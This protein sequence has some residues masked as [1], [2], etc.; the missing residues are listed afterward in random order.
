[1]SGQGSSQSSSGLS[2]QKFNALIAFFSN[3]LVGFLGSIASI[4]SLGL[5]FYFYFANKQEPRLT[6]YVHPVRAALVQTGKMS[7][8]K[9]LFMGV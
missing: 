9:V 6:Y 4:L 5:A 1:M 3:P 2:S 8:F 7:D